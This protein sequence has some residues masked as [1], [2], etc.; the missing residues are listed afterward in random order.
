MYINIGYIKYLFAKQMWCTTRVC[1]C[2]GLLYVNKIYS[3]VDV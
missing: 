2:I 3:A 1:A